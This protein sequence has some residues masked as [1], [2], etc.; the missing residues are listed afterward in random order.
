MLLA[1][2]IFGADLPKLPPQ[3]QGITIE[4]HLGAQLPLDAQFE[5]EN[6]QTVTLGSFFGEK[7]VV[8][9]LVYYRC[10]MLCSRIMTGAVL[11]LRPLNLKAG[12]DYN[13]VAISINPSETPAEAAQKRDEYTRNYSGRAGSP[14]WHFLV[15]SP[16]SIKAVTEAAGFHYRWDPATQMYF[17]ASAIMMATPEGKMSRYFYG[18]EYEPKDLELGL[19]ESSRNKIGSP[20]D[21]I[22]LFCSHYDPTTGKYTVAV[23][24]ILRASAVLIMI[25]MGAGFWWLTRS[26]SVPDARI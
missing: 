3:L 23:M 16:E 5:D 12:R 13:V 17:H 4:Q 14:G 20:A 1:S 18:V 25:A 22:L 24:N 9:A 26:G 6:G 15:G 10:P 11:G 8:L 19:M 7:P 21:R 2:S